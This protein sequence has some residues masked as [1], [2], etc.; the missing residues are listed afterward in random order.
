LLGASGR[1]DLRP[2][3]GAADA[4]LIAVVLKSM[5]GRIASERLLWPIVACGLMHSAAEND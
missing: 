3:Q 5:Q 2:G 1:F 4:A